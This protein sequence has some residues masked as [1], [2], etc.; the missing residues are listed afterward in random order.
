VGCVVTEVT[1]AETVATTLRKAILRGDYLSGE[2]L[3]ELTLAK[4]LDVSQNTVR[5]ALRILEQEGWVIKHA[6]RGV[7]VQKFTLEEAAEVF[8]L[9]GVLEGL[10]LGW[11]FE[12]ITKPAL[13]NLNALVDAARKYAHTGDEQKAIE[14]LFQFHECLARSAQKPLTAQV[15][16]KL[17]NQA[18]L[19][20]AVRQA[21][22]PRN[23][24]EL[25]LYIRRLESL[26]DAIAAGDETNAQRLLREQI[27]VYADAV[28]GALV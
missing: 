6:R 27:E 10:A 26:Y 11:A 23:L 18:R 1:R 15:I 25:N 19:L 28:L 8:A 21:R 14:S 13:A 4:A 3:V 5:D 7:Y 16:E 12:I 9:L 17:Y 22:A 2:R 20:E 24:H